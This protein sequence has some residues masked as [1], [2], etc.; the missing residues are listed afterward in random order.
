MANACAHQLHMIKSDNT[1]V[2]WNCQHCYSG[3]H[4]MIWECMYCKL[5][6]CQPC[7]RE[8]PN[9]SVDFALGGFL[10]VVEKPKQPTLEQWD[11]YLGICIPQ[12]GREEFFVYVTPGV[13]MNMLTSMVGFMR[14]RV[15]ASVSMP[16]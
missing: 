8:D 5:H 4:W 15:K 10:Y 3:P 14:Q 1:L 11:K 9:P 6:L 2:Q 16:S 12:A 7:T 13:N